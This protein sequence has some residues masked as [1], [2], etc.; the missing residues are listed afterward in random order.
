MAASLSM[1]RYMTS[2][3]RRFG[4]RRVS[5]W[6]A[7]AC[8]RRCRLVRAWGFDRAWVKAMRWPRRLADGSR[9]G[10]T[11]AVFGLPD[12]TGLARSRCD[13]RRRCGCGTF[14]SR[15]P[16]RRAWLRSPQRHLMSRR[17]AAPVRVRSSGSGSRAL[18]ATVSSRT[19]GDQVGCDPAHDRVQEREPLLGKAFNRR[20]G[21]HFR[22]P[23]RVDVV[24]VPPKPVDAA[25]P[26]SNQGLPVI[27]Q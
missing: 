5:W 27:H 10:S 6:V 4:Q 24:K 21:Q 13:G 8:C 19:P 26:L 25:G 12:P 1:A 17:V 15:R 16:R 2:E 20:Q 11:G 7:P 9:P 22:T 18:L 23:G 3:R 14:R